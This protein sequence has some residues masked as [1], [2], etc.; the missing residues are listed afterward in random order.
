MRHPRGIAFPASGA[1]FQVDGDLPGAQL[2]DRRHAML[3]CGT[4]QR[5]S[6]PLRGG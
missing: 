1:D 4:K 6:Q 5:L 3:A 2:G